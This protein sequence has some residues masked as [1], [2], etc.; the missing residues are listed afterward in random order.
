M[1]METQKIPDSKANM[2]KKN[3]ARGI[4]LPDFRLHT[5]LK[6]PKQYGTGTKTEVQFIGTGQEAQKWKPMHLC[7]NNLPKKWRK[8]SLFNG[9]VL[10]KLDSYM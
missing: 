3:G 6:S 5:K 8:H 9:K 4:R 2:R 1:C 10:G 7:S